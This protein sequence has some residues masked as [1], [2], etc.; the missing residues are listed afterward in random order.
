MIDCRQNL[1]TNTSK[2][3]WK[4]NEVT[5]LLIVIYKTIYSLFSL[6]VV[7]MLCKVT[8]LASPETLF[9]AEIQGWIPV[10]I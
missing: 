1:K 2:R 8:E 10:S 7:I 6:F 9:L 3:I 4:K 5:N